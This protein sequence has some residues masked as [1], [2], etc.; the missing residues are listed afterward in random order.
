MLHID[1]THVINTGFERDNLSFHIVKGR[2]KTAY[3]RSFLEKHKNE[4]GIIYTATRKQADSLYDLLSK[5]GIPVE[6]YHAGLS[7]IERQRAQTAYI[8]DEKSVMIATTTFVM[9]IDNSKVSN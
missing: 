1:Y 3:V 7:E 2:D 4:S 9:G 6:K 8:H 5:R